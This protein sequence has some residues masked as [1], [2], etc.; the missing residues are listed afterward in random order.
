MPPAPGAPG[1]TSTCSPSSERMQ[2]IRLWA[3][4]NPRTPAG[5][6]MAC[7]CTSCRFLQAGRLPASCTSGCLL[8][9]WP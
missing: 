3:Q 7:R 6:T 8:H 5:R 1:G 2:A 4:F 9:Q